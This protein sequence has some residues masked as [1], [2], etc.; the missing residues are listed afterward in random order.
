MFIPVKAMNASLLFSAKN[1]Q[2]TKQSKFF[3]C[4]QSDCVKTPK[5]L[6]MWIFMKD[7]RLI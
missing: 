5:T 2:L 6:K 3:C 1:T 7:L 4:L